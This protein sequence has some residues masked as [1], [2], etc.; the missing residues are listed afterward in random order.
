MQRIM[1]CLLSLAL[2]LVGA[3]AL[4]EDHPCSGRAVPINSHGIHP[5]EVA[6]N[7]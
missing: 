2:T 4:R 6:A 7:G 5:S 3:C 1:T